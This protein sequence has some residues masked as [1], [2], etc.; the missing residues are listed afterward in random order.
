MASCDAAHKALEPLVPKGIQIG[1]L[2]GWTCVDGKVAYRVIKGSYD[3]L[4]KAWSDF[5]QQ[6]LATA[7]SA[8]R[9][10]PGDVYVCT[11]MDHPDEPGKMLTV[12][13]VPVR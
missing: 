13:Y 6:A 9:G 3:Q 2:P 1:T 10:P 11:P 4:P 8:P 5:P 7:R 12:L